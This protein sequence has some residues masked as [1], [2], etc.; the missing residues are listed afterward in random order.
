LKGKHLRKLIKPVESG[1]IGSFFRWMFY[2]G[3]TAGI[4]CTIAFGVMHLKKRYPGLLSPFGRRSTGVGFSNLS[5]QVDMDDGEG[6]A[7]EAYH[8]PVAV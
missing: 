6:L 7:E 1:G 3:G 4:V 2:I 8:E 5:A